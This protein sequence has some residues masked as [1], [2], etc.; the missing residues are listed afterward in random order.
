MC[1]YASILVVSA[2]HLC[3]CYRSHTS[4]SMTP[5]KALR[6]SSLPLA[7][8]WWRQHG[9][10]D[11][12]EG[13]RACRQPT[14][15]QRPLQRTADGGVSLGWAGLLAGAEQ[16]RTSSITTATDRPPDLPLVLVSACLLSYPVTYR[17]TH[18]NLPA[19]LRPTPLLFL[20]EV[21]FKE[22]G[23]VQCVPV[24]PEV[25]WLGLPVPRV[26]LRLVRGSRGT[27]DARQRGSGWAAAQHSSSATLP[28]LSMSASDSVAIKGEREARYLVESSAEDHVLLRCDA[29]N[30][31][32][33]EQSPS[34][35]LH[36]A[37][38]AQLVQDLKAVDGI[39]LKSY[40]PSCGVRDAR[41]YEEAVTSPPSSPCDQHA[42]N[43]CERAG[44]PTSASFIGRRPAASASAQRRFDLVD[45][46]FTQQLRDFLTSMHGVGGE[47]RADA[48]CH[49]EAAAPVITCD[50]LLTDFY[51]EERLRRS[52]LAGKVK[53]RHVA[54]NASEAAPHLTSLDSFMESVLQ[55]RD[56]RVS[57]HRC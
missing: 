17:G 49:S 3:F 20:T 19:S 14:P 47:R 21:L 34:P 12:L 31:T 41:L 54:G 35:Q 39:I 55:H 52:P 30:D 42:C 16:S 51:T 37:F 13:F 2:V 15:R 22:L 29:P 26:P 24:C 5:A 28:S 18:T 36:S 1:A 11:R 50:R 9:L 6:L 43:A 40:S 8:A 48:R 57:Q 33:A 4:Q 53:K 44:K 32:F 7:T 38:L 45:G 46:F 27:D 10:A 23:L 56:W 25:Q